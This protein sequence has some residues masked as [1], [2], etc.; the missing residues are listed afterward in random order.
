MVEVAAGCEAGLVVMHMQGEPG[1][2]QEDPRYDDVVSEVVEFLAERAEALETAGVAR[3]RICVD[4]GI[5]FGKT[6]EHN[7]ELLRH[8]PRIAELGYPVLVGVSRKS[9]IGSLLGIE[10]PRGRVAG[11]VGASVW[12]ALNGAD[13]LRVHDVAETVDALRV[14]EAIGR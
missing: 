12:C 3:E 9:M 8:L 2:M 4:P 7:L 13:V 5:G 10:E 14:A 1:T 6:L 11:S